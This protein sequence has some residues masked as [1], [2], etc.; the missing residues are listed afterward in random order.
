MADHIYDTEYA[1]N[2]FS[3]AGELQMMDKLQ[4]FK[5]NN[6]FDVGANIGEWTKMARERQPAGMFHLF[7][8]VPEVYH[9]CVSAVH[10]DNVM[11]NPFGLSNE[12]STLDMLYDDDNDRLTT[13]C[14]ELLRKHPRIRPLF[15][16][17]G[18]EYCRSRNVES[19]DFLKIDTEG[20]EFKVLKGFDTMLREGK[21]QTIQFEYGFANVLTKD[22]LIDFYRYLQPLGYSIGIQ[23]PNGVHFREYTLCHENFMG[24][25]YVAVHQSAPDIICEVQVTE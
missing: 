9:R 21:I 7:E 18:D 25:N 10:C 16:L 24:P 6:I 13:P 12:N 1:L 20:H 14:L 22:L 17:A 2:E 3:L 5:F 19:I 15:M 11:V 23:T 4:K 8:P